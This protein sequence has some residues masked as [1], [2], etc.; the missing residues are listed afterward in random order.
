MPKRLTDEEREAS[1]ERQKQL[2]KERRAR[3]LEKNRDKAR[4]SSLRWYYKNKDVDF[5]I[6]KH[7][8]MLK[9]I[10]GQV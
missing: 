4:E 10:G 7:E 5:Y 6:K 9:I 2:A 8:H 1:K 3:W